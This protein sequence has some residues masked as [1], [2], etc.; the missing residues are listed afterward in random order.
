MS[1]IPSLQSQP[2]SPPNS[3]LLF[4]APVH[5]KHSL[6]SRRLTPDDEPTSTSRKKYKRPMSSSSNSNPHYPTLDLTPSQTARIAQDFHHSLIARVFGNN[7]HS[8]LLAHRLR[9][10]LRLT[11]DLDVFELELGFFVL[12]F[13]NSSDYTEALE[14]L[15]WSISHLCIHV[16]PWVPN[17]KP[18]EA[19]IL[20]VDVW[21]RLPELGIEYYDK[22]ILEK[23][24]EAIG[25]CLVKIDPVTERRQKCMFARICIR[26]TLCNPLIYSIQFGQTLQKVQYEGLDSLCSVCGC[27]DNLKHVCLNPNNPSGSSGDDPHQQNPCPLQ[28]IDPSSSS[29]LALD[30]KKPLIH[31]LPSSESALGSKSQEKNP[32]LELKLKD[33]PKLKMGKVVENEKK[34]LPNFPEESS[35]TTTETP[36][37]VPLAA[38]LVVDQFRAAKGS[39]PT[40]LPVLNNVSHSSSAVEAGINSFSCAIQQT[41][42]EKKMINTP[43]GGIKVVDSWPTVYTIDPTTM[44]LGI[45]FSEVPTAT[46]SNQN[47]YAINFVLNSRRE[48]DNEV[49]SKAASMP[50]LCPKKMLC[51]NFRGMDIAK[52]IQASKYL[53]RLDEPSIVLIFGS[54]ISSADAEE[55]VRELA[56]NGSYCR[57]P[58]GYNGGVWMILSGQDV[59]IEVSSYS[60]QKVSASVYFRSKLNE[61]EVE[62]LDEDTETSRGDRLSSMLQQ[63]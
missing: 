45:D 14:E 36:E 44:S 23:I 39:S 38:P 28:A 3:N 12:K 6:S 61:P 7:V 10:Y 42:T 26:I 24:A 63:G 60:P 4:M 32:F 56:F 37:S 15:P 29:G 35:T 18:S 62:L 47:R 11:G 50:P 1:S 52:L 19:L 8:R 51:W 17:F 21:I 59:E 16:V 58:D 20:H 43:F 33:C 2:S 48:N 5:S 30:S 25:V 53:I 9:R 49:D 13:S 55:V 54:K 27:I 31:S 46:G 22:E 41:I 34:I 40:K 57:K